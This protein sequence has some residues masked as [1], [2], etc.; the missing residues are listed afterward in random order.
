MTRIE[1][2]GAF[3]FEG[4]KAEFVFTE[5]GGQGIDFAELTSIDLLKKMLVA[6]ANVGFTAAM[7]KISAETKP[8]PTTETSI[9]D[10]NAQF[11]KTLEEAERQYEA[12]TKSAEANLAAHAQQVKD[13]EER[14]QGAQGGGQDNQVEA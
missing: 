2:P 1:V 7:T 12:A 9:A 3:V 11:A 13:L 10:I 4:E 5:Y 8:S 6:I 14:F